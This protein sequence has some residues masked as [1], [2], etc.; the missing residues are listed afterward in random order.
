MV[1]EAFRSN[2]ILLSISIRISFCYQSHQPLS[3]WQYYFKRLLWFRQKFQI[4]DGLSKIR[5]QTLTLIF[6]LIIFYWI[7]TIYEFVFIWLAILCSNLSKRRNLNI[8]LIFVIFRSLNKN[9][10]FKTFHWITLVYTNK[11]GSYNMLPIVMKFDHAQRLSE[12]LNRTHNTYK[13]P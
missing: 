10:T 2:P 6:V 3:W 13:Y 12:R 5:R 7:S 1:I 11:N 8:L 4:R 9:T